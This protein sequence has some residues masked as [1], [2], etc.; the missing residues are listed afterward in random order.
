M[1]TALDLAHQGLTIFDEPVELSSGELSRHFVDMK[2]ALARGDDL[3]QACSLMNGAAAEMPYFDAMGGLSLGADHLAHGMAILNGRFWFTV[4]KASKG[5]GTDRTI[6]WYGIEEG[7]RI[8]LVD[9]VTTSGAS[10]LAAHDAVLTARGD[11]VGALAFVDRGDTTT[12][13]MELAQIPYRAL[14]GYRDLGI[15]AVGP[16]E[17]RR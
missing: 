16:R 8:L 9:D 2:A 13:A 6:E 1:K 17:V 11:V 10:L 12:A 3:M 5:R 4:R 14:V 7:A 15:P